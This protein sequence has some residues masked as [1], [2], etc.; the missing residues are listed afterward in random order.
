M[1]RKELKFRREGQQTISEEIR[2]NKD[3]RTKSQLL[4]DWKI[5]CSLNRKKGGFLGY[6]YVSG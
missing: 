1:E 2:S 4:T 3:K 6:G 5:A